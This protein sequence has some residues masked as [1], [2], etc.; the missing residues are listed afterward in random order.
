[1]IK[2][3][4]TLDKMLKYMVKTMSKVYKFR[5]RDKIMVCKI[6]QTLRY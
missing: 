4:S 2:F 3:L 1:M 5:N 6:I